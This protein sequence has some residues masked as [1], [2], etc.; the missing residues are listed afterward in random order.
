MDPRDPAGGFPLLLPD[1]GTTDDEEPL[2]RRVLDVS[3]EKIKKQKKQGTT[4]EW[5]RKDWE[6][7][8][9][10]W[11]GAGGRD[12]VWKDEA[13]EAY[14]HAQKKKKKK[15]EEQQKEQQK[16]EEDPLAFFFAQRPR[17]AVG[18]RCFDS[19]SPKDKEEDFD[20]EKIKKQKKHQDLA[21]GVF[22]LPFPLEVESDESTPEKAH[23]EEPLAR[24][25]LDVTWEKIKKQKKHQEEELLLRE[26]VYR[27]QE[28]AQE[29]KEKEKKE[30][31]AQT[32]AQKFSEKPLYGYSL[33]V[34]K[35][36][37]VV[38]KEETQN[39]GPDL[40]KRRTEEQLFQD[41]LMRIVNDGKQRENREQ[42]VLKKF[43]W[44]YLDREKK[45]KTVKT[46]D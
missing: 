32:V 8:F 33:V 6:K 2:A 46:E 43:D 18:A 16:E 45:R 29:E 41:E 21:A 40:K 31:E 12:G 36:E 39:P 42:G 19:E 17:T 7:E 28:R 25:V 11:Y 38:M 13:I 14:K 9:V 5:A 24:Q 26:E 44:T 1:K 22:P 30:E 10:E 4:W 3:W 34:M 20:W 35:K 23:D 15:E 37:E 27:A